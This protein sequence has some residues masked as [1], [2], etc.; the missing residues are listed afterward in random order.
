MKK[1]G[2]ALFAALAFLIAAV[3]GKTAPPEKAP[4]FDV[5]SV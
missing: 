2:I 4:V 3:P 5:I 1:T